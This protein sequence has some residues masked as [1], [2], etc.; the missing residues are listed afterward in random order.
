M[1]YRL[2]GI[3]VGDAIGKDRQVGIG[4][5][6]RAGAGDAQQH[7]DHVARTAGDGAGGHGGDHLFG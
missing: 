4:V 3:A 7:L 1:S 5:L 6:G 2:Y